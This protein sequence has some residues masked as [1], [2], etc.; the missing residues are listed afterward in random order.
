MKKIL[1]FLATNFICMATLAQMPTLILFPS[2]SWMKEHNYGESV[3]TN[4]RSKWTADYQKAFDN[5]NIDMTEISTALSTT[6]ATL[7]DQGFKCED[8][9]QSMDNQQSDMQDAEEMG[10]D[11]EEYNQ[12]V[13]PDIRVDV[14]WKLVK[15]V[16]GTQ[17][18]SVQ[19]LAKDNYTGDVIAAIDEP[20]V[21]S[22]EDLKAQLRRTIESHMMDFTDKIKKSFQRTLEYG[23]EI[24]V[25]IGTRGG[26]SFNNDKIGDKVMK[27]Y[28]RDVLTGVANKGICNNKRDGDH[29]QEYR[30]RVALGTKLDV[31]AEQLQNELASAGVPISVK[32]RTIGQ[33]VIAVGDR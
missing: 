3:T 29:L 12:Q 17:Q 33:L 18:Y 21:L 4:G 7:T 14:N 22:G 30:I 9:K 23:R 11:V 8:L 16:L 6:S 15:R 31:L 10:F 26:L 28:F 27:Y 1:T 20:G 32:S 24:K 13:V 19:L 25:I 2:D 5:E